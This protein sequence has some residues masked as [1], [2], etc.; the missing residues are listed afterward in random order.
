[1]KIKTIGQLGLLILWG[2]RGIADAQTSYGRYDVQTTDYENRLAISQIQAN[3]RHIAVLK[4]QQSTT[5]LFSSDGSIQRSRIQALI[6]AKEN[7][8]F[9]L[10]QKS[11]ALRDSKVIRDKERLNSFR[12]QY[13]LYKISHKTPS[14]N[15]S[16]RLSRSAEEFNQAAGQSVYIEDL[17]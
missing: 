1:M 8:N 16:Y 2:I 12:K 15:G 6:N 17:K 4:K 5:S 7:E 11:F 14:G 10:N 9:R 13:P 3:S